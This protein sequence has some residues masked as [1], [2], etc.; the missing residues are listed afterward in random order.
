MQSYF[1]CWL[2]YTIMS[3]VAFGSNKYSTIFSFCIK[4]DCLTYGL[5]APSLRRMFFDF[6]VAKSALCG[7]ANKAKDPQKFGHPVTYEISTLVSKLARRS[8]PWVWRLSNFFWIAML[9]IIVPVAPYVLPFVMYA[10]DR[11]DIARARKL[12]G[13]RR[14]E[15]DDASVEPDV[16]DS[17]AAIFDKQVSSF[18]T[19]EAINQLYY[20]KVLR[21]QLWYYAA[22]LVFFLILV[23][24][25]Y[26]IIRV[27]SG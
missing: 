26:V 23:F 1:G 5:I 2:P 14:G 21:N 20:S 9:V 11:N 18:M 8:L 10:R 12:L 25:N 24:A 16:R 7:F 3:D 22:V 6:S 19:F 15:L 17:L 27:Q 4:I 13:Q